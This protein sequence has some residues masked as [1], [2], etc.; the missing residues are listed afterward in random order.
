ME[1]WQLALVILAAV[2]V[3]ASIPVFVMLFSALNRAGKEIADIGKR[4]RPT[5]SHLE[6]I[7][8]RV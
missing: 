5:L 2:L 8:E 3:G 4:L 1:N 7:S 6:V